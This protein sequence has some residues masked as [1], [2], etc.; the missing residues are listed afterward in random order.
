MCD[1]SIIRTMLLGLH[2]LRLFPV[3]FNSSTLAP[4]AEPHVKRNSVDASGA[5]MFFTNTMHEKSRL[6][7]AGHRTRRDGIIS[8]VVP[9]DK[10]YLSR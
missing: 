6:A 1:G 3:M 7:L 10:S 2:G 4:M 9:V 5:T 8:Q